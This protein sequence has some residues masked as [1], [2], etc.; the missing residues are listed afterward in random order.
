MFI[1]GND[2]K[3]VTCTENWKLVIVKNW[4]DTDTLPSSQ[5]CFNTLLL[6][7]YAT[8]DKIKNKL[9]IAIF[10]KKGFFLL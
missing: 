7:E 10:M 6:P 8:E 9:G 2:R 1:T 4:C 3:P 5:T